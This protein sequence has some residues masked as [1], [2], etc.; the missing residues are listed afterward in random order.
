MGNTHP[1]EMVTYSVT[2]DF[3]S[4]LSYIQTNLSR[5]YRRSKYIILPVIIAPHLTSHGF[6]GNTVRNSKYYAIIK[7]TQ[8]REDKIILHIE[9]TKL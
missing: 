9:I 8:L 5:W 2:K 1:V 7:R 3:N 6:V 4:V